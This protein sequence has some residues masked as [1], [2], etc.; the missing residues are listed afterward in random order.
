MR[1]D[2]LIC[3]EVNDVVYNDGEWNGVSK[4]LE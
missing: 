1:T 3:L 2:L 4:D